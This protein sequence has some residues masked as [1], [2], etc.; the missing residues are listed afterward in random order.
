[1]TSTSKKILYPSEVNELSAIKGTS[2]TISKGDV[3]YIS[4]WDA[5]NEVYKI[6]KAKADS[7][8]T[9]SSIGFAAETI[10]D[11]TI[12]MVVRRGI[13]TGLN[14]SSF[15]DLDPLYVSPTT[16]GGKQKAKPRLPYFAEKIG[17]VARSH[18]TDGHIEAYG[19]GLIEDKYNPRF[20]FQA[21]QLLSPN[22]ADW[23]VNALAPS[24][25]DSNNAALSVR[26]FDKTTEEGV[27]FIVDVPLDVANMTIRLQS[28]AEVAPGAARTVGLKLYN[29][30]IPDNAAVQTWSTGNTLADIDIPANEY[31][32]YDEETLTLATLGVTAGEL[33]QFELTRIDPSA[34]TELDDDWALLAIEIEFD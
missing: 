14:T 32:Q 12:G 30:G 10:T 7:L 17:M 15:S 3:V 19:Y 16:A 6:E 31:F 21:D 25:A 34:G 26:L 2:G 5:T 1:M 22:N 28:R 4:G 13:I 33:T 27:G 29:R 18:A 24:G 8:T 9:M 23:K 20:R 11:T